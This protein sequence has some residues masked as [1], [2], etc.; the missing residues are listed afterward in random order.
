MKTE[1]DL[2]RHIAKELKRHEPKMSYMKV[3]DKV[4]EG[5][6][7]FLVWRVDSQS[8]AFEVK[9][10]K[11]IPKTNKLVLSHVFSGAQITR[12]ETLKLSGCKTYGVV[13]ILELETIYVI[14][15]EMIPE[16]GNWKRDDFI[17]NIVDNVLSYKFS[18]MEN[19]IK[20]CL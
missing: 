6:P 17:T 19:F 13:G 3:C 11:E 18:E 10:A 12:L 5:I 7:D 15:S 1:N 4:N 14:P 20:D 16:S 8:S 2:N 9:L